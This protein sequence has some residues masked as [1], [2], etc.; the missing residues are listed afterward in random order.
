[1]DPATYLKRRQ[2]GDAQQ[3]GDVSALPKQFILVTCR[4]LTVTE[5]QTL[6]KNFP[7]VIVYHA[8]L[9]SSQMDLS[10]MNFDLLVI[11]ARREENHLFLEIV[12]SQAKALNI[13]II[14]LKKTLSNY[15][16]L[17]VSLEAYV[18]SKIE[19]LDGPNFFLS[20][21]KARVPKLQSRW[22]ILLKKL[23]A[24]LSR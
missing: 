7:Q 3:N 1:M 24:L 14:V 23:F 16:D 19:Q 4:D 20:L 12:S 21:V 9:N 11:D 22:L 15:K 17:A 6:N 10:K 2:A 5:S 8:G 13:P 18:L